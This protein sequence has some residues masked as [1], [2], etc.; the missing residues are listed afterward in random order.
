M[1]VLTAGRFAVAED[2]AGSVFSLWQ[3]GDHAG[4]GLVNEPG[5]FT[6]NELATTDLPGHAGFLH[7][8]LRLGGG[9]RRE[10]P[11]CRH[12]H[13]RRQACVRCPCRQPG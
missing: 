2:P 3:P 5:A 7:L 4:A 8:G 11:Q 9:G 13:H 10:Q 12:F 1:E 6:W